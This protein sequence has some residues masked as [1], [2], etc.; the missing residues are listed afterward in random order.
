MIHTLQCF[1]EL[2]IGL[3]IAHLAWGKLGEESSGRDEN[4]PR[5]YVK[6]SLAEASRAD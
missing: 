6:T 5:M 4:N 3:A 1:E 2:R